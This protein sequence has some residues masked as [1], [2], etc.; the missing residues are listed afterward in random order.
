MAPSEPVEIRLDLERVAED[1]G[2]METLVF[3]AADGER[4]TIAIGPCEGLAIRLSRDPRFQ[5]SNRARPMTHDLLS[6]L[7]TH[8]GARLQK[9]VIDDFWRGTYFA[10][11]EFDAN[12]S[13][14]HVDARPSDA[15][16]LA[17]RS[18]VEVFATDEVL[19]PSA[20]A[21]APGR[22]AADDAPP[23]R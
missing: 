23:N 12:G 13:P 21:S 8:F 17:L 4:L 5:R 19:H 2:N 10:R 16:A 9:V 3:R 15:V 20:D 6:I 22:L 18:Q 14:F 11:L 7:L 1:Q